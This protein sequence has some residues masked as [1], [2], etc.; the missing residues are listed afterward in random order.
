MKLNQQ[1]DHQSSLQPGS[2]RRGVSAILVV[3][4]LFVFIICAALT[5]DVA[6]MQLIR[7]ELRVA[8]DASARA[9]A[10]VLARTEDQDAA[11]ATAKA[12]AQNNT[13]AGAPLVIHNN[14]VKFGRVELGASGKWEFTEGLMPPNSVRVLGRLADDAETKAKPLFFAPSLGH[15]NFSTQ[16]SATASQQD[17]E[18]CLVLDRSGSMLFDMTG[19]ESSYTKPNPNLSSFT[20]WG[21]EWQYNLSP[22][23]PAESRW[24]VLASAVETF[25]LEAGKY[26]RP[27]RVSLV[28][29]GADY[30][31]PIPPATEFPAVATD[32]PLPNRYSHN[33]SANA[34]SIRN[35]INDR[36]ALPMMGATNMAAGIDEGAAELTGTNATGAAN[37]IMILLSDG[38]W[39]TGDDPLLAAADA[40][41]LGIT[42]HTISMLS[43]DSQTLIDIAAEGN[44]TFYSANDSAALQAAFLELARTLPIV[45]TE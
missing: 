20:D 19:V 21:E 41:G 25:L 26:D 45:L 38:I 14:D 24:A 40:R 22:P 15:N 4:M 42:I 6:Y 27:P 37:K 7:T 28:T 29:W 32:T 30:T 11:L 5:V 10:E 17:T 2:D 18:V 35:T 1:I 36:S 23:H 8:T 44:G 13:V 33:W 3:A 9:A 43:V 12:Y 34:N 31:M 39:N 16:H